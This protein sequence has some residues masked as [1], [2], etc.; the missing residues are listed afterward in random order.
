LTSDCGFGRQSMSRMHAY[1]K[2]VA[3]VRG[4]NIVR[5]ELRLPEAYI[6]GA[7]PRLSM[8]PME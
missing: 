4:A 3:L 7:D 2:M 6:P 5:R 1:Y 8:V